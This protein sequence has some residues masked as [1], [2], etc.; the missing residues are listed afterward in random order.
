MATFRSSALIPLGEDDKPLPGFEESGR[1]ETQ[2]EKKRSPIVPAVKSVREVKDP[3]RTTRKPAVSSI[4]KPSY[5]AAPGPNKLRTR[6]ISMDSNF[7]QNSNYSNFNDFNAYDGMYDNTGFSDAFYPDEQMY[8]YSSASDQLLG[9]SA[10]D[11]EK[12]VFDNLVETAYASAY[13]ELCATNT[14]KIGVLSHRPLF[15]SGSCQ[16]CGQQRLRATPTDRNQSVK[17]ICWNARCE[18]SPLF[19]VN[20]ASANA[21]GKESESLA[22]VNN[23]ISTS[24][25]PFTDTEAVP[26]QGCFVN[27]AREGQSLNSVSPFEGQGLG[28]H[29]NSL[30]CSPILQTHLNHNHNQAAFV[31][32]VSPSAQSEKMDLS[33]PHLV[34]QDQDQ[35]H[36]ALGKKRIRDKEDKEDEEVAALF[37]LGKK[38]KTSQSKSKSKSKSSKSKSSNLSP[39][40]LNL[41]NGEDVGTMYQSITTTTTVVPHAVIAT[42]GAKSRGV[43]HSFGVGMLNDKDKEPTSGAAGSKSKK[44]ITTGSGFVEVQRKSVVSG[45]RTAGTGYGSGS[46][47]ISFP[48]SHSVSSAY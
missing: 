47:A 3:R 24:S 37:M 40:N 11:V 29:A 12:K 27:V 16:C 15:D 13:I 38:L 28:H 45:T 43:G 33:S 8:N 41:D 19:P 7:T 25:P 42:P 18:S 31:P 2:I 17:G 1:S 34:Q 35:D 10:S 30:P 20:S 26:M 44:L 23:D 48:H 32:S 4:Q 39:V 22:L 5:A 14:H 36:V 46:S 6:T 9:S 21:S